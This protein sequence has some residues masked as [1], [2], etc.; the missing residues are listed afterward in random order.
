MHYRYLLLIVFGIIC[1]IGFG[2]I[3]VRNINGEASANVI[4]GQRY[5]LIFELKNQRKQIQ[6]IQK[7][8]LLAPADWQIVT[9][10]YTGELKPMERKKVFT[11]YVVPKNAEAKDV[12]LVFLVIGLNGEVIGET[13]FG[14]K[15][16]E[17]HELMVRKIAAPELVK[18]GEIIEASFEVVNQGN[19]TE[20]IN[21]VTSSEI[22]GPLNVNLKPGEAVTV[23]LNEKTNKKQ[24]VLESKNI[25]LKAYITDEDRE[26]RAYSNTSVYP[27]KVQENDSYFRY[28]I[29]TSL[30][31][32]S[33]NTNT[34]NESA[35][36]VEANGTGYLDVEQNHYLDFIIRTPNHGRRNRFGMYDRYTAEYQYKNDFN[37]LIGD[38]NY[39]PNRLGFQNRYGFGVKMDYKKNSFNG[40]VFYSK[41]RLNTYNT[42]PIIGYKGVFNVSEQFNIALSFS[43][44]KGQEYDLGDTTKSLGYKNGQIIGVELQYS[45]GKSFIKQISSMSLSRKNTSFAQEFRLRHTFEKLAY[46][47]NFLISGKNFLGRFRNSL[48]FGNGLNYYLGQVRLFAS[49][50]FSKLNNDYDPI[51]EIPEPYFETYRLGAG[52]NLGSRHMFNLG[53]SKSIRED[54][55]DR[56][57]T[58]YH[59]KEHGFFYSYG[60]RQDRWNVNFSGR[61]SKTKDLRS[62]FSKYRNTYGH[63][64][65]GNFRVSG[66]LNLNANIDHNYTN[67]YSN[68]GGLS[69]YYH[70]GLGLDLSIVPNFQFTGRYNSGFS[71]EDNFLNRDYVNLNLTTTIH[72]RHHIS[73]RVNLFED[74][75]MDWGGEWYSFVKYSYTFGVPL[76]K[77]RWQ[78]NLQGKIWSN[79]LDIPVEDVKIISSGK[80]V[81]TN[82]DGSFS[83]KNLNEGSHFIMVDVAG[84]PLGVVPVQKMPVQVQIN[85]DSNEF[86]DIQ[87]VRSGT[88]V[89]R[90]VPKGN[91]SKNYDLSGY[92]KLEK[93]GDATTLYTESN[94]D[95]KFTVKGMVPGEYAVTLM[96]LKK[97]EGLLVENI[98]SQIKIEANGISSLQM[99][100]TEK[101]RAIKFKESNFKIKL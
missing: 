52:Y 64:I 99:S 74:T 95:G 35:L 85:T 21:L 40:I 47:G 82:E 7:T 2:Q 94:A 4:P 91:F 32:N 41:P 98:Y 39:S 25:L 1:Q 14:G 61:I 87:L 13:S 33:I 30:F 68:N 46:N 19:V 72:K 78:G 58:R 101:K 56:I 50:N 22:N 29:E 81:V 36:M 89:G 10:S 49:Q 55:Q 70:Y 27:I 28:P 9:D 79:D 18:A 11:T 8:K 12:V 6:Y 42:A 60:Y 90:L 31:W 76:K 23:V 48:Q 43:H 66:I 86:L 88:L 15:V 73:A 51:Y 67:R 5:T 38:F 54:K 96:R 45:K 37:L 69:N 63:S 77:V 16:Q 80:S 17:L 71:P 3:M 92:L 97:D 53:Y 65:S 75:L 26:Y 20:D 44:S 83:I 24:R 34:V 59:Y 62:F 100:I 93:I 57:A 84:L